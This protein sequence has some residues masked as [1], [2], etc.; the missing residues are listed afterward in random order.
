MDMH[1]DKRAGCARPAQIAAWI[2]TLVAFFL[3]ITGALL[4][5]N[6]LVRV[7]R[8]T[9][10][11]AP[12]WQGTGVLREANGSAF[13][14]YVKLRFER[15]HEGAGP[16]EGKTNLIGTASLCTA[17]KI[18]L[19]LDIS[20][21]LDAWWLEDGKAVTLYF[22]TEKNSNPKLFFLLYGSWQ[23]TALVLEDR[24]TLAYFFEANTDTKSRLRSPVILKNAQIALHYGERDQFEALCVSPT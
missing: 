15:K 13:P 16:V 18:P 5:R 12:V 2:A 22:H 8:N 21:S 10:P 20:G 11:P 6:R 1:R 4:F 17:E 3:L 9:W 23:G 14:L 19:D 7:T 24:G